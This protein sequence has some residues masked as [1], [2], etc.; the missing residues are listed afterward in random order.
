MEKIK[1]LLIDDHEVVR[2]GLA[3]L[4]K[5]DGD[6]EVVGEASNAEEAFEV[7][8]TVTPSVILMDI[9]MPGSNG[10]EL[11]RQI[12][13]KLPSIKILMMTLHG[14][15]LAEAIKAGAS[16]YILKDIK[17]LE[18]TETIK[19]VYSGETVISAEVDYDY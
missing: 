17:R 4:I 18:L 16:G 7:L 2:D 6:M 12:K 9:K 8:D 10:I 11:T 13:R 15:Y 5:M 3:R 19:R 14:E 1:I